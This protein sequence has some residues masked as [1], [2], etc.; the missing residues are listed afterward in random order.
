M[1]NQKYVVMM[2]GGEL[3]RIE[4]YVDAVRLFDLVPRSVLFRLESTGLVRIDRGR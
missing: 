4:C 2:P 3:V 1:E